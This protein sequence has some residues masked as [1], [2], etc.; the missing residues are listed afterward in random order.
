MSPLCNTRIIIFI[1]C[2]KISQRAR[3]FKSPCDDVET[4]S[5]YPIGV[6]FRV[7]VSLPC[8]AVRM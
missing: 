2:S 8:V 7:I 3:V 1:N 6:E 4:S 5:S